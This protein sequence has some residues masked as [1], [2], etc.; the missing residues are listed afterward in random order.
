[1][2]KQL[3]L[4]HTQELG[5]LRRQLEGSRETSINQLEELHRKE[6]QEQKKA[7]QVAVKVMQDM[8]SQ[9]NQEAM[10]EKR[11]GHIREM[12]LLRKQYLAEKDKAVDRLAVEHKRELE[13]FQKDVD[14]AV[15]E[16]KKGV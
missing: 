16:M 6:L 3:K 9:Q 11:Q 15:A 2:T 10:E 4:S 1:M 12:T 8:M 13:R 14:R 5:A 7:N